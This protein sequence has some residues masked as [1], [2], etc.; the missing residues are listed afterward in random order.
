MRASYECARQGLQTRMSE[1]QSRVCQVA[2]TPNARMSE[3]QSRVCQVAGSPNVRHE[4][5]RWQGLQN[6][7]VIEGQSRVCRGRDSK[8][9]RV[10]A[11]H[12]CAMW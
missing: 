8:C 11:S 4:C 12:E 1:G 2:G 9:E 3:G 5:A 10:R 7:R 6:A